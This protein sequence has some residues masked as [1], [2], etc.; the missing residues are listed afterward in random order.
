MQR[1]MKLVTYTSL[2]IALVFIATIA[3][4]IPSPLGGYINLGDAAIYT[5]SYVLGPVLGFV[6]GGLGSML[7]DFYLGFVQYMLPTLIIKGLMG[8]VSGYLF[9]KERYLFGFILG[10]C[11]MTLGYYGYEV[12]LYGNPLSPLTNIPYN[13]IQGAIGGGVGY[14]LLKLMKKSGL[15][16]TLK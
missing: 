4:A 6:A 14:A 15:D 9:M 16:I 5:A 8:A 13:L 3:I 10:L 7:G 2:L 12:I 11:I 1:N